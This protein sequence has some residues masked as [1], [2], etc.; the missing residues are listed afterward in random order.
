MTVAA[1]LAPWRK[2]QPVVTPAQPGDLAALA[3]LHGASFH[4][5]WDETEFAGMLARADTLM[6]VL[7]LGRIVAGFAASRIAADESEILSIAVAR[8]Q[9]G[10][11]LSGVLLRSHLGHLAG[12]GVRT[13]FLEVDENNLPA[14]ALYA[15]F[16][17]QEVGR[18]ERY[19]RDPAG[20][21][22]NALVLRRDLS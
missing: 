1:W 18:R 8:S 17:F 2:P 20:R 9:R 10:R 6:H 16:G 19:Y 14:R 3:A 22:S 21:Q 4:R 15:R 7:R 13:V 5:G 11:G 12:R